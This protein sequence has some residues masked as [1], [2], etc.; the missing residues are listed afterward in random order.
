MV[1]AGVHPPANLACLALAAVF[2]GSMHEH[3]I[4]P[5]SLA[6]AASLLYLALLAVGRWTAA[7]IA[8][9]A[10]AAAYQPGILLIPL[11][12][13]W[14]LLEHCRLGLDPARALGRTVHVS[15][16]VLV[17]VLAV[18]GLQQAETGRWNGFLLV[19]AKYGTG[20]HNPATTFV[21]TVVR[22]AP[23]PGASGQSLAGQP[24]PRD[25]FRLVTI[26][27]PVAVAATLTAGEQTPLE[28]AVLLYTAL[29]WL[30]PLVAGGHLA[31]Y[32]MHALLTPSVLLPRRLP[33]A[34][35][36]ILALL[37]ALVAWQ[38]AGLF[39]HYILI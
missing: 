30:A 4:F 37:S 34:V 32:R 12:P 28:L 8:G 24:A 9:A 7:G 13:L 17:G 15:A 33:A 10:A 14:L 19:E 5:I 21:N 1:A 16:L 6:L 18:M 39:H 22:Q 27:V 38:M 31:Q 3:A 35:A 25:Q 23:P 20:L 29:F 2:P 36:G 11:A 26:I